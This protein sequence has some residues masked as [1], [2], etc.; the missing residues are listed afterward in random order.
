MLGALQRTGVGGGTGEYV[1][2][3]S[4]NSTATCCTC[5]QSGIG[6][7]DESYYR[8]AAARRDPGGLLRPHRADVRTRLRPSDAQPTTAA[9]IVALETKIA[10]AHWDVVK[11][12]DA[13]LTYNLR[14]FAELPDRGAGLRLG[15]LGHRARAA[16]RSGFAEVVVRQPD[17]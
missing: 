1:D 9:R 17:A 14:T 12:R 5:R 4:K 7:P 11:R 8:D 15:R 6:L 3:D 2:T 13:D 10:A 16:L